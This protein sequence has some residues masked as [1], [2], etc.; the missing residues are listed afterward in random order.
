MQRS[1]VQDGAMQCSA[2]WSNV[3]QCSAGWSNV[4]QCSAAW[5]NAGMHRAGWSN[6]M[7]CRMERC[8]AVHAVQCSAPS[9][10]SASALRLERLQR[11]VSKL[12]SEAGLCEEQLNQADALLQAELRLQ[13]AGKP[14]QRSA[15]LQ[16]ELEQADAQLRAL[17]AD[18]QALKDGRHP[19]GEQMYRRV[20][21]LHERLVALRSEHA[22]HA[23]AAAA[24]LLRPRA[25]QEEATASQRRLRL[26]EELHA[27]VS[28]AAQELRWLRGRE[29]E[30]VAFDWSERNPAM[31]AKKDAYATASQRRLRLLEELQ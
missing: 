7:Q 4:V 20:Y 11:I 2:A 6:A 1:P 16:R 23:T 3:V 21:R 10:L 25:E 9:P 19:Q 27:L 31:A 12:Q 18:V 30:E 17:F 8:N 13:A 29:E 15:E 28:G 24:T 5:S 26:L 14:P 22:L